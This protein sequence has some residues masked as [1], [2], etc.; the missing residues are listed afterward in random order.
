MSRFATPLIGALDRAAQLC[1]Q[2]LSY[3]REGIVSLDLDQIVLHD[4]VAEVA[5]G[6]SPGPVAVD[7]ANDGSGWRLGN[8]VTTDLVI[9]ADRDQMHR[10]LT[11]LIK[12]AVEA[13]ATA[14]TVDAERRG[15]GAVRILVSD[16]GPGLPKRAL[17]NLFQPF[18]GSARS[19]G[20]GLGLAN[21]REI[22]RAHGG[23]LALLH[24]GADGAMFAISL[25]QGAAGHLG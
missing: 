4:L 16:D 23:D 12:N 2:T 14:V 11:N 24:S 1:G 9:R 8:R 18:S 17:D 22:L 3:A 15:D 25:P 7:A 21:A 5:S 20:T 13:K 6:L 10:V 19:G